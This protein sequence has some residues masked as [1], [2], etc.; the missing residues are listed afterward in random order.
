MM[1]LIPCA[2]LM[3]AGVGVLNLDIPPLRGVTRGIEVAAIALG[4]GSSANRGTVVDNARKAA[5]LETCIM[6]DL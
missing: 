3:L 6:S 4:S 1:F 5:V 2:A